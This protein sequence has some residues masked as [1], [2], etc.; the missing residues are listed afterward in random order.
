MRPKKAKSDTISTLAQYVDG[1]PYKS[2][3]TKELSGS[4]FYEEN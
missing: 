4:L 3:F 1:L 2:R